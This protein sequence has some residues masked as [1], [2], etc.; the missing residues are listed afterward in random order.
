M[1]NDITSLYKGQPTQP[2]VPIG[3]SMV[4]MDL[5]LCGNAT[6]PNKHRFADTKGPQLRTTEPDAR[7]LIMGTPPRKAQRAPARWLGHQRRH[8]GRP[9]GAQSRSTAPP[10]NKGGQGPWENGVRPCL[11]CPQCAVIPGGANTAPCAFKCLVELHWC[12]AHYTSTCM[13]CTKC[14]RSWP[15]LPRIDCTRL[16]LKWTFC[17]ILAPFD[18]SVNSE[19]EQKYD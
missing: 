17:Y 1:H 6:N 3:R 8:G 19:Q 16:A 7:F 11:R 14:T 2:Q 12:H 18:N 9:F 13:F 4:D 10:P 5:G 15:S